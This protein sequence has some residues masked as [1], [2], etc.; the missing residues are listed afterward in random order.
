LIRRVTFENPLQFFSQSR[1][2]VFEPP[3]ASVA[4]PA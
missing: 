1:G 4:T 2:F 3:E